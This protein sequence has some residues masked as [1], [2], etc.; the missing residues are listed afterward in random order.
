MP[1]TIG[2]NIASL[3]AQRRLSKTS[4]ELGNVYERLSS[5]MRINKASDDAA[6]LSIAD[7]LRTD[8][9]IFNQGVRNINDGIS[10]LN[11]ANSAVENLTAI[12]IRIEELATQAANGVYS[13]KQRDAL[14][15]EAQAL[16]KEFVR[17]TQSTEF[18]GR[19]L[20]AAGNGNLNLQAGAGANTTISGNLSGVVGT[21]TFAAASSF[22]TG[23]DVHQA[24]LAD[25]N[26]D[27][28]SDMAF[29]APNAISI[30]VR[31]GNGDGTFGSTTTYSDANG[32]LVNGFAA[33]FNND[34][35]VDIGAIDQTAGNMTVFL[36]NGNGTFQS[37]ITTDTGSSR[38]VTPGDFNGDG[39]I[40][41]A[42][43]DS[44]TNTVNV[45]LGRGDGTFSSSA[46]LALST[47]ASGA[48]VGDINGDGIA[49][50]V[51][52]GAGG[53]GQTMAFIGRGN[54]TF[55]AGYTI[56]GA[57]GNG[58]NPLLADLNGDSK[59]DLISADYSGSLRV[60]IG[61]GDGNFDLNNSYGTS[62]GA[63]ASTRVGDLNGDGA[64][65]MFAVVGAT[66]QINVFLNNGDG[67]FGARATYTTGGTGTTFAELGDLNSDGVLDIAVGN[68]TNGFIGTLL[69]NTTS[70]VSPILPFS[71]KS[72]SEARQAI[73]LIQRKRNQLIEQ[74]GK[75]GSFQSRAEVAANVLTSASNA[76][77]AAE[78]RI[79][80]ADIAQE[81]ADLVRLNILQKTSASILAQA[82][83]QPQIALTLLNGGKR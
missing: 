12:T 74:A 53:A 77:K 34:G 19:K 51:A 20:F 8:A 55:N 61:R 68:R 73:P 78:S 58:V 2:S 42:A 36:G 75:I 59:L 41:I 80:D 66:N 17:L 71:L 79:R 46:T 28:K 57:A 14:D 26:G 22:D 65:D 38:L 7:S 50:V 27:G 11:I 9:R 1:I 54:G 16:A 49:D 32:A 25:Y 69:G 30:G 43:T 64:L 67:T 21:G 52:S 70:G 35:I 76:Y 45:M 18:N 62:G 82:N 48:A 40:D 39:V 29:I 4:S 60:L 31:M 24:I 37:A 63:T 3:N 15:K 47:F 44:N 33:D 10:L 6:G 83:V 56:A 81:A 5:G 72:A 23:T 13:T